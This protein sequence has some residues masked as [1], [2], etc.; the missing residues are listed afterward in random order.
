VNKISE[1][2]DQIKSYI[3]EHAYKII[4][5]MTASC[6]VLGLM[7]IFKVHQHNKVSNSS[8]LSSYTSTNSLVSHSQASITKSTEIR[9][10]VDVKGEVRHP[11][12]YYFKYIPRVDDVIR[13]AGGF[14]KEA[15]QSNVNL[16]KKVS[17]QD[18]IIVTKRG[19]TTSDL[20]NDGTLN[21]VNNSDMTDTNNT[22]SDK[23][24]LNSADINVLQK[25]DRVGAKKAQKIIN[26]RN[27]HHG[28]K[29]IEELKNISGFGEKTFER[30]KDSLQL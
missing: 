28:F 21:Q 15:N 25:L 14:T 26:Y 12:L 24:S 2:L 10:Y 29:K 19:K 30:L 20:I 4:I 23:V 27:E 9:I 1:I 6:L 7:V 16:A 22:S 11:G 5:I 8:A 18:T 3:D 13:M 17:D